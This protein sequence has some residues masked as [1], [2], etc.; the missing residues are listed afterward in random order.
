VATY[1]PTPPAPER[2]REGLMLLPY[3]GLHSFQ[4]SND[5]GLDP[6]L[7]LGTIVGGFV[8]NSW[9]LNAGL[10]FDLLNPNTRSTGSTI[11][12]SA[13][14]L[15]L[16]L[17]PLF[18]FGAQKAE[19]VVG[20]KVG[21][22][23]EWA[24]ASGGGLTADGT[25]EGWLLGANVGAFGAATPSVLV[26]ALL[27]LEVRDILHACSSGTGVAETCRSSG[28]SATILGFSFALLL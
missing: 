23:I 19:L 20:P 6:G 21:G 16:S 17:S 7:R 11:D 26:G 18:H 24:H 28:E 14:M 4:D 27:S 12:L 3:L 9:S 1:L 22:W 15:G 5:E 10:D 8:N 13:E 25:A 2:Q